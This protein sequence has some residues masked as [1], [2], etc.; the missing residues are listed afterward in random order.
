VAC[1]IPF[2]ASFFVKFLLSPPTGI[3]RANKDGLAVRKGYLK[4]E[5]FQK[6]LIFPPTPRL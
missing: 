1:V 4:S 6:K 5:D 3:D 2:A